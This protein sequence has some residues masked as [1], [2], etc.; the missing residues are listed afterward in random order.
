MM[1]VV[2]GCLLFAW[3]MLVERVGRVLGTVLALLPVA[4]WAVILFVLQTDGELDSGEAADHALAMM[5]GL[6]AFMLGSSP[7][8]IR[9]AWRR[10]RGRGASRD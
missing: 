1:L 6:P 10:Y 2:I 8:S 4:V 7:D 5:T 9:A 3:G